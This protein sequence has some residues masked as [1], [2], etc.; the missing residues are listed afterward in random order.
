MILLDVISAGIN[1][2]LFIKPVIKLRSMTDQKDITLKLIARKQCVLSVVAILT[3]ILAMVLYGLMNQLPELFVGADVNI[4]SICVIL[5][6]SY[7][8]LYI[9]NFDDFCNHF[10][11]RIE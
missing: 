3:T 7:I 4:S 5:S 9:Q 11:C 6:M 10:E 2:Y 1:S 8:N